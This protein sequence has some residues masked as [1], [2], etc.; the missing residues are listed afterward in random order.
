MILRLLP[1]P[2]SSALLLCLS[3]MPASNNYA[4]GVFQTR[5]TP[6]HLSAVGPAR[7]DLDAS[8]SKQQ[9]MAANMSP[10]DAPSFNMMRCHWHCSGAMLLLLSDGN[11]Y[12]ASLDS[13]AC[14]DHPVDGA[15]LGPGSLSRGAAGGAQPAPAAPTDFAAFGSPVVPGMFSDAA[16]GAPG[17]PAAMPHPDGSADDEGG[18][19]D[20]NPLWFGPDDDGGGGFG[21]EPMDDGG[22]APDDAPAP[23][24]PD[25]AAAGGGDA[26]RGSGPVEQGGVPDAPP[27]PVQDPYEELDPHK[28]DPASAEK[29][30]KAMVPKTPKCATALA[31]YLLAAL[32]FNYAGL[33]GVSNTSIQVDV[34]WQ[35]L[36]W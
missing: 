31:W 11:P 4:H 25:A 2:Q 18:M 5:P 36:V 26:E 8:A 33:D 16:A 35:L 34:A 20:D 24:D 32:C 3:W 28:P 15:P 21:D 10:S 14:A 7:K 6:F 22:P 19:P 23:G 27:A 13:L 12:D 29:P 1:H 9:S 17:S 30:F